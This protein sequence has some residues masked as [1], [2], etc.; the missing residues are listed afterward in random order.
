MT[1]GAVDANGHHG[2][3][4]VASGEP[5]DDASARDAIDALGAECGDDLGQAFRRALFLPRQLGVPVQVAPE[6]DQPGNVR[7]REERAERRQED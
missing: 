1:P 7:V 3:R 5:R 4:A 6:L 2:C